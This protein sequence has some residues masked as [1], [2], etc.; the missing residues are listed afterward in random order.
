MDVTLRKRYE[1]SAWAASLPYVHVHKNETVKLNNTPGDFV[2][3]YPLHLLPFTLQ[4]MSSAVFAKAEVAAF[5]NAVLQ[6]T[7]DVRFS[8]YDTG[9]DATAAITW[10]ILFPG[11]DGMTD[12]ETV[13]L[14]EPSLS[15]DAKPPPP[16][17]QPQQ[18]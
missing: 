17:P 12:G 1:L 8:F 5:R 3:R 6:F 4:K 10:P 14:F 11:F 15:V 7:R 18:Q 13:T 9:L 16:P 2:A